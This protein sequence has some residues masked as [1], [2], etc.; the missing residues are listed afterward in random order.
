MPASMMA[1]IFSGEVTAGPM[2]QT[3]FTRRPSDT[4]FA[5]FPRCSELWATGLVR[6]QST[7]R[8]SPR[9]GPDPI[10]TARERRQAPPCSDGACETVATNCRKAGSVT[11][12][13]VDQLLAERLEVVGLAAGD[14]GVGTGGIHHNLLVDPVSAGVADVRLKARPAGEP[15]PAN[16]VGLDQR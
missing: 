14:Q 13:R 3:I 15:A 16:H 5:A 4:T 7:V 1:R 10:R 2:V 9:H 6:A 11:A 8:R 12:D